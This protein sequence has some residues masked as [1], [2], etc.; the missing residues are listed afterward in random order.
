MLSTITVMDKGLALPSCSLDS[1]PKHL[2]GHKLLLEETS[3]LV[4]ISETD[5]WGKVQVCFNLRIH[6]QN[7]GIEIIISQLCHG[8]NILKYARGVILNLSV[9]LIVFFAEI[10]SLNFA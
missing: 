2:T 10:E 5:S 3:N 6:N 1:W 7:C 9:F 8:L 4:N